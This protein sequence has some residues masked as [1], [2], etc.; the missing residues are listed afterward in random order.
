MIAPR[1]ECRQS[2]GCN[3][4][5]RRSKL[6]ERERAGPREKSPLKEEGS[7]RPTEGGISLDIAT[8]ILKCIRN[9]LENKELLN[10]SANLIRLYMAKYASERNIAFFIISHIKQSALS[11]LCHSSMDVTHMLQK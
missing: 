8:L 3:V 7:N 1:P 6:R 4:Y 5:G 11:L 2:C 9:L 10:I